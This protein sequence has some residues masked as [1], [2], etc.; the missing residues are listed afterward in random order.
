MEYK[1]QIWLMTSQDMRQEVYAKRKFSIEETL[2]EIKLNL[3]GIK[4]GG[5]FNPLDLC[6]P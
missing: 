1:V 6:G 5:D 3:R 4:I 2:G